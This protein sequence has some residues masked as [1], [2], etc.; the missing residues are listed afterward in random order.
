MGKNDLWIA[1]TAA[2]LGLKLIT[3]DADFNHL[4][5]V[6]IETYSE[7]GQERHEGIRLAN[8]SPDL[9]VEARYQ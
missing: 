8:T 4:H 2:L 7:S 9:G 5:D 1:S 6:F 3:T